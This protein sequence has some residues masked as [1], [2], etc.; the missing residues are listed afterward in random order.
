MPMEFRPFCNFLG[1]WFGGG[2]IFAVALSTIAVTTSAFAQSRWKNAG[3]DWGTAGN[4]STG[5]VPGS[6]DT[7]EFSPLGNTG[8]ASLNPNLTSS[9]AILS[10]KL[11]PNFQYSGWTFTRTGAQTLTIGGSG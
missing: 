1:R 9:Q 4:W 8:A 10:L 11:N 5:T 7:V 2:V 3:T 6:S